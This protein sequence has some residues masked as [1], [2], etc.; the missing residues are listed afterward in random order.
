MDQRMTLKDLPKENKFKYVYLKHDE[1]PM[2][3]KENTRLYKEFKTLRELHKNDD[4]TKIILSKG[5][6]YKND[7]VVDEFNLT[8]QNF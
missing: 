8:N 4:T 6:L 5:K 2:T 1:P 7:E 3:H